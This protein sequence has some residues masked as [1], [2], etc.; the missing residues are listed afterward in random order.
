VVNIREGFGILSS[1][2]VLLL[3]Y[4]PPKC[5]PSTSNP[6]STYQ[7]FLNSAFSDLERYT[8]R[9]VSR[10]EVREFLIIEYIINVY[11][12]NKI[13]AIWHYGGE[14]RRLNNYNIERYWRYI[15]CK[16]SIII[17]KIIKENNG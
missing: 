11:K 15:Y 14:R 8:E 9:V 17:L 16:G 4:N 10:N 2:A 6:A 13:S 12:N 7:F 3:L 5:L 1:S